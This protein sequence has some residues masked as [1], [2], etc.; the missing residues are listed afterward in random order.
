MDYILTSAEE[1][2]N[3]GMTCGVCDKPLT[4]DTLTDRKVDGK[5]VCTDCVSSVTKKHEKTSGP[6]QTCSQCGATVYGEREMK[7][8]MG[9]HE[10][11]N[12]DGKCAIKSC[13]HAHDGDV[14]DDCDCRVFVAERKN[15]TSCV[16][17]GTDEGV[18]K[19]IDGDK[20]CVACTNYLL[21]NPARKNAGDYRARIS[22]ATG[23][24]D[25]ATL[26]RLED[27]MR[28][29]IFHSTLD[30]LSAAEFDQGAREAMEVVEA[31]GPRKNSKKTCAQC[32][33]E[34]EAHS[35]KEKYC[36]KE[37]WEEAGARIVENKK[38]GKACALCGRSEKEHD[39]PSCDCIGY[40]VTGPYKGPMPQGQADGRGRSNGKVSCPKCF[41]VIN[42]MDYLGMAQHFVEAHGMS[43]ADAEA[44]ARTKP[45][46]S[47]SAH[48]KEID[49]D[50]PA[51]TQEFVNKT[52]LMRKNASRATAAARMYK[53]NFIEPGLCNYEDVEGSG[54]ILITKP[55]IDQMLAS[56]VGCPVVD[57]R[58][59]TPEDGKFREEADGIVTEAWF[60]PSDGQY[61]CRYIVWDPHLQALCDLGAE[62]GQFSVS[63][64]YDPLDGTESGGEWHSIPYEGEITSGAFT[65]LAIVP[66]PRYEGARIHRCNSKGGLNMLGW[67]KGS[68]REIK[69]TDTIKVGDKEVT[70]KELVE[71]HNAK[72]AGTLTDE[73]EIEIGGKRVTIGTL[74]APLVERL[75]EKKNEDDDKK[76]ED[77]DKEKKNADDKK[78]EEDEEERKNAEDEEKKKKDDEEERKNSKSH[79]ESLQKSRMNTEG[80]DLTIE[81]QADRVARG[82]EMYGSK[83]KA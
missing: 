81:S 34:F 32:K 18:V 70:I 30:W 1:R 48:I 83:K 15:A 71:L 46:R 22:R 2:Q 36:S 77:D 43:Q 64:A 14:C 37:C 76:K 5:P 52:L 42:P 41:R 16:R 4:K 53:A 31:M 12:S 9:R 29:V 6:A 13:G 40:A 80:V 25:S 82:R 57:S 66:N 20:Y 26:A 74:K 79:F 72:E 17:C 39:D 44:E 69:D 28:N 10:K 47:N 54:N 63:C 75:N 65:H 33:K 55:T 56:I 7:A 59:Q 3:A 73:T 8:H 45:L 21:S 27:L 62:N 50:V 78:K 49:F 51:S 68:K 19:D 11:K 38:N 23:V 61:W 35:D 60:E 24:T 58:H 67:L